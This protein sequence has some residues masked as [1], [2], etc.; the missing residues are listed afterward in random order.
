MIEA[1]ASG[2]YAEE[3]ATL[4]RFD[5]VKALEN[6]DITQ[7]RQAREV[8]TGLA[9]SGAILLMHALLM[10]DTPALAALRARINELGMA[11]TLMNLA[12]QVMQPQRAA[13][14]IATCLDSTYAAL[15]KSLS[16]L[17]AAGPPLLHQAGD[18]GHDPERYMAT[19]LS[20]IREISK[21]G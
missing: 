19:W 12:R 21:Q 9:G 7:L 11:P 16:E 4:T 20:S 10:P 2:I 14:A 13:F 5:P 15:Y 6:A 1:Y 8:A 17:V 3:F 18:D